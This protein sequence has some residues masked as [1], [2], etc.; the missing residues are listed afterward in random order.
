MDL[1]E[2]RRIIS[3]TPL[4]DVAVCRAELAAVR[5]ARGLIDA[6]EL[7]ITRRLDE[8]AETE[9]ILPEDELAKAS[10][11]SASRAG[12]VRSRKKA[13]DDVPELGDALGQGDTTGERLELVG[14]ALEGLSPSEQAKVKARGAELARAAANASDREFRQLL[15]RIVAAAREDDGLERLARQRRATRLRWWTGA[16]GMWNI[17]G[18][19]DPASGAELEGRIRNAVERLFHDATPEDCPTDPLE[20]QQ[21]LAAMALLALSEG[22][23]QSGAPDVSV[24]I[25]E[26]TLRTGRHHD[27][28][29]LDVGLGRFGLPIET[30]RRWACIGS[31]T[32]VITG[33]DGHRLLMGR[34]IRTANREQRR[35]LRVLYRTCALCDVPFDH[36]QVHHVSWFTLGEGRTDIDN[37]LPLCTRHHHRV[38]EG[39]WL[40]DLAPDRTLTVTR[41]G[42]VTSTHGPPRVRAA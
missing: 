26:Q 42:G 32:P 9:P 16:D 25:D 40:L 3:A 39:G 1:L 24:V 38:H 13:A 23:G 22:R 5:S 4:T 2:L 7:E 20:R 10:K 28:T 29:I 15:D 41:P 37:L 11:S 30:I 18:S 17:A 21:F 27:D 14:R 12:R 19:F 8:L 35:A 31:I 6:R 36:C 34:E 33:A